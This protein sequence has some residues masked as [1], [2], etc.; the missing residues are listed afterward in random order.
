MK[1]RV[2]KEGI[3]NGYEHLYYFSRDE[4]S[5]QMISDAEKILKCIK[6]HDVDT[7][8]D[9]RFIVYYKNHLERISKIRHILIFRL[10][11]YFPFSSYDL[12]MVIS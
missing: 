9:L 2:I 8:N 6:K 4:L 10:Q 12:H 3:N 11:K 5:E 7:C 1:R